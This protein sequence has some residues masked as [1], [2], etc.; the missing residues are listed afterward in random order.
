MIFFALDPC[1]T[2]MNFNTEDIEIG[3]LKQMIPTSSPGLFP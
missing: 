3:L 1:K 2:S